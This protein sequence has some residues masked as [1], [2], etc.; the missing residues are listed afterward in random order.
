MYLD[1]TKRCGMDMVLSLTRAWTMVRFLMQICCK[2]HVAANVVAILYRMP[3]I[4]PRVM[5]LVPHARPC[6][7][8]LP[9]V[10]AAKAN[11]AWH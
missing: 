10:E 8:D 2:R 11:E 5:W 7:K 1:Q 3:T 9:R 4:Q 6:R